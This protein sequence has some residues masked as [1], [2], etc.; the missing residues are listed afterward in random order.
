MV[1][2]KKSA[3]LVVAALLLGAG[4]APS[5]PLSPSGATNAAPSA[6]SE[7]AKNCVDSGGVYTGGTCSCPSGYTYDGQ[8]CEDAAGTP[9]GVFGEEVRARND[10]AQLTGD[11]LKNCQ[12]SGGTALGGTCSCPSGYTYDGQFCE[13]AAGTPGGVFGEEVR[14]RNSN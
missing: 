6:A 11:A 7:Q 13:D 5:A 9:G 4:C 1:C 14:A 3:F 8:F 12:D 2:L 10:Q